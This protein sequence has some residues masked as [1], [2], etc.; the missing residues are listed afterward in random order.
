MNIYDVANE[1]GSHFNQCDGNSQL[2]EYK[3]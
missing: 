1:F 2:N 3:V